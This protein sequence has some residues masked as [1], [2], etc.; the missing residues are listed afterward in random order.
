MVVM[1]GAT[2]TNST[3]FLRNHNP[4]RSRQVCDNKVKESIQAKGRHQSQVIKRLMATSR[5]RLG[6]AHIELVQTLLV[7]MMS[8][9]IFLAAMYDNNHFLRSLHQ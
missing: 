4:L 7:L 2:T 5:R 1:I 3:I 6:V 8:N 9:V